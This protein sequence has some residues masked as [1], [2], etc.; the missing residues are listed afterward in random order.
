MFQHARSFN[1]PLENWNVS[2]VTNMERMFCSAS[3][4]NQSLELWNMSKVTKMQRMFEGV[5]GVSTSRR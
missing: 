2:N 5:K 3:S 1:Q 4:F